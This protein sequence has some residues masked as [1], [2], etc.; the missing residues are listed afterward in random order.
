MHEDFVYYLY[1]KMLIIDIYD[2]DTLMLFG[3]VKVPMRD[4]LRRGKQMAMFAKELEIVDPNR[5][6]TKG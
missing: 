5:N 1:K 6:G 2:A 4:L 3:T